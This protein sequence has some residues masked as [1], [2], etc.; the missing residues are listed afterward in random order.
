[1]PFAV[2]FQPLSHNLTQT[3]VLSYLMRIIKSSVIPPPFIGKTLL[4]LI[5]PCNQGPLLGHG[6]LSE[7]LSGWIE[8]WGGVFNRGLGAD[9]GW[10]GRSINPFTRNKCLLS[11]LGCQLS[12]QTITMWAPALRVWGGIGSVW[13][14]IPSNGKSMFQQIETDGQGVTQRPAT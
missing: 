14:S 10:C 12:C 2:Y 9:G 11:F 13:E 4:S 8:G 7:G 5:T 6:P 3:L 1:M